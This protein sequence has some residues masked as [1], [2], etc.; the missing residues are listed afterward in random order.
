MW[1][2]QGH[3]DILF[4]SSILQYD[5]NERLPFLQRGLT[6][7][8]LPVWF[9]GG[10][11]QCGVRQRPRGHENAVRWARD[12]LLYLTWLHFWSGFDLGRRHFNSGSLQNKGS[13]WKDIWLRV[14]YNVPFH[15]LLCAGALSSSFGNTLL[16]ST[17]TVMFFFFL[18]FHS[19]SVLL[20]EKCRVK[21]LPWLRPQL[22]QKWYGALRR[23][24]PH[25][26]N[27]CFMQFWKTSALQRW[28]DANCQNWAMLLFSGQEEHFSSSLAELVNQPWNKSDGSVS[29]SEIRVIEMIHFSAFIMYKVTFSSPREVQIQTLLCSF[30]LHHHSDVIYVQLSFILWSSWMSPW[31]ARRGIGPIHWATVT[32]ESGRLWEKPPL[33]VDSV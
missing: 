9:N 26:G 28:H 1:D 4:P 13:T 19:A 15:S 16:G 31:G 25:F 30:L 32:E 23:P 33:C 27:S 22:S 8:P 17:T 24:T 29:S 18:L 7:A 3:P 12:H 20:S 6:R 5:S 2:W 21:A 10:E 14:R 11:L